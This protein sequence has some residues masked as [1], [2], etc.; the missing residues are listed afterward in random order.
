VSAGL[1]LWWFLVHCGAI[2]LG[3]WGGVQLFD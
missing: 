1:R 2:A 3:I